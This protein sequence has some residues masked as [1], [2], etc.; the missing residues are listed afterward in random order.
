VNGI[1]QTISGDWKKYL[2]T[3]SSTT[4]ITIDNNHSLLLD[5]LSLHPVD[6]QMTTYTYD[7][8]VGMS[9]TT[10]PKGYT[11]YFEYDNMRRLKLSRDNNGNILKKYDYHF[12]GQ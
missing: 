6:A 8:L 5:D 7:P 10:D 9:S 1:T 11:T 3:I 4:K 2:W 12:A